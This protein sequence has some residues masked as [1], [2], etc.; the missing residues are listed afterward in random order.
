MV[1]SINAEIIFE[2]IPAVVHDKKY[3][4]N[5]GTESKLSNMIKGTYKNSTT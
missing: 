4:V 1:M 2:K 3:R 5:L